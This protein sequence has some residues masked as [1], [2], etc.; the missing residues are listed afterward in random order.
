VSVTY[1]RVIFPRE[2]GSDE[3]LYCDYSDPEVA[4]ALA[5]QYQA[6]V[7][8]IECEDPEGFVGSA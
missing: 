1:Y 5:E 8:L 2:P 6:S 3:S 4:V 7:V